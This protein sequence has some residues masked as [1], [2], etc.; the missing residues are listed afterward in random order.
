MQPEYVPPETTLIPSS[1][2]HAYASFGMKT[3]PT[4]YSILNILDL[5]L[6]ATIATLNANHSL[7]HLTWSFVHFCVASV[8][9][10]SFFFPLLFQISDETS[11]LHFMS[12]V[13]TS[14]GSSLYN[15]K[16]MQSS[17][18]KLLGFL[19]TYL[20]KSSLTQATVHGW[21]QIVLDIC[22]VYPKGMCT[23]L[24]PSQLQMLPR[25]NLGYL[26]IWWECH[27]S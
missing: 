11:L 7:I 25:P 26:L 1:D 6:Y 8:G 27:I 17:L 24:A 20:P 2:T 12:L 23:A 5:D 21:C 14:I 9:G 13:N 16:W 18:T 15:L 4:R 3:L 10:P 19:F 22:V